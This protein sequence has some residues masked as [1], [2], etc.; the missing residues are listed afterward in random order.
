MTIIYEKEEYEH[1]QS[2]Y[3]GPEKA[4]LV[5]GRKKGDGGKG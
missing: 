1:H 4:L 3:F 5:S 2:D